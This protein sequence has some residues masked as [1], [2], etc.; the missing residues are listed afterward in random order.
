VLNIVEDLG[1]FLMFVGGG[2]F[3]L[4]FGQIYWAKFRQQGLV[5]G[6][7]YRVARHP[8]Y[9]ALAILGLGTLLIWP[10]Y[11]VLVMYVTM[12]FLYVLLARWEEEQ[13]ARQFGTYRA[14]QER[15]GTFWPRRSSMTRSRL[16]SRSGGQRVAMAVTSYAVIMSAALALAYQLRAYS[17]SHVSSLY[18]ENMAVLSPAILSAEELSAALRVAMAD[19]K[20]KDS[21][22]A[23][24]PTA[25]LLVYVV[26]VEWRLP[27]LPLERD[28]VGGHHTPRGFDRRLYKI[29]FTKVRAHDPTV[30][31]R[32][33]VAKA[34]GL[35]PIILAKVNTE[36]GQVTAIDTPPEHVRWGDIPTPLF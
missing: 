26:P 3:L 35:D 1:T 30:T 19:D 36:A 2:T 24:G 33:I 11:L 20:V 16:G 28:P 4:A 13:C 5:T 17:L 21:L 7:L 32:D 15:T 18:T 14:Y 12:L 9:V 27:D 31:G 22:A 23:A 29:L 8:Q 34:Y 10:R 25:K 6:G